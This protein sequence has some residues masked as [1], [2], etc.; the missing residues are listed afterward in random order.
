MSG[1]GP[2]TYRGD[3]RPQLCRMASRIRTGRGFLARHSAWTALVDRGIVLM[4]T[5][6][7]R[8]P[9]DIE[10]MSRRSKAMFALCAVVILALAVESSVE[11]A[12]GGNKLLLVVPIG[13]FVGL[14]LFAL[15]LVN[16][17]NFVFTTI[18]IRASLDIT[19]PGAGNSGAVRSRATPRRRLPGS[20][21]RALWRSSSFSWRSCGCSRGFVRAASHRPCRSTGSA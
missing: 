13:A 1:A 6:V 3:W 2:Y 15:G 17:E 5:V 12:L 7:V 21:P 14:G 19:K 8:R 4:A 16:F 11:A 18:A 10:S 9:P 20:T